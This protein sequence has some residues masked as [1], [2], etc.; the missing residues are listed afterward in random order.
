MSPAPEASIENN[1]DA[2]AS[3][4]ADRAYY[5]SGLRSVPLAQRLDFSD[6][7]CYSRCTRLELILD[8]VEADNSEGVLHEL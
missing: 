5:I 3:S 7:I 8:Q 6:Y 4:S 2:T 1:H